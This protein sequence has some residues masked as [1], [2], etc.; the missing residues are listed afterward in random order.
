[1]CYIYYSHLCEHSE[2]EEMITDNEDNDFD[3]A[4]DDSDCEAISDDFE[5]ERLNLVTVKMNVVL[6]FISLIKSFSKK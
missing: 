2:S 4:S 1:M 5:A 3:E 6:I